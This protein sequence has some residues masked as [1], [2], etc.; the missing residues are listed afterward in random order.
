[1]CVCV[2]VC[3]CDLL[4]LYLKT[5]F[6]SSLK[7]MKKSPIT[8]NSEFLHKQ[9]THAKFDALCYTYCMS[10]DKEMFDNDYYT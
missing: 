1:V 6:L 3:V 9:S 10:Q 8:E 4:V 5:M 7:I 2:C